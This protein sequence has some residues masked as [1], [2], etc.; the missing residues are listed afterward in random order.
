MVKR[1][2]TL[3]QP[4]RTSPTSVDE[5]PE[6]EGL[7][8]GLRTVHPELTQRTWLRGGMATNSRGV[9]AV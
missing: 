5:K 6:A 2:Q 1:N 4:S 9:A 7:R 3:C 8:K